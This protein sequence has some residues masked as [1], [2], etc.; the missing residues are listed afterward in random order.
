MK[1]GRAMKNLMMLWHI[2][3]TGSPQAAVL[4]EFSEEPGLVLPV[5]KRIACGFSAG[6]RENRQYLRCT[7]SPS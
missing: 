6:I 7:R 3:G 1:G 5:A 2:F 4:P